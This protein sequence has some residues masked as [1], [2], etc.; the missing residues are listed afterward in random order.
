MQVA[1][2]F[3]PEINKKSKELKRD[4]PVEDVLLDHQMPKSSRKPT[5]LTPVKRINLMDK[6]RHSQS[7]LGKRFDQEFELAA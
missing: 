5:G 3:R 4:K 2:S 6:R 7:L 1:P